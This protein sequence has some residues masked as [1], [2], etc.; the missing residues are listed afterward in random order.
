ML[1]RLSS[2]RSKRQPFCPLRFSLLM[3]VLAVSAWGRSP[4]AEGRIEVLVV[5]PTGK[6]VSNCPVTLS[7]G[8]GAAEGVERRSR[9]NESGRVLFSGLVAG[10]YR[11]AVQH[12][13]FEPWTANVD[14]AA[15]GEQTV[16]A[17]L[18]LRARREEVTVVATRTP[19]EGGRVPAAVG[20]VSREQV[21]LLQAHSL[22]D[23]FQYEPGM[24][25]TSTLRRSGETPNIRGMD[26]RRILVLQDGARIAEFPTG[27]KGYLFL[28]PEL[29]ERVE[30]LRGPASALYGS[31]ALG[32]VISLSTRDP[33]E[34]LGEGR[35]WDG[36]IGY[37]YST[38][39]HENS[40][41]LSLFGTEPEQKVQWF[42]GYAGRLSGGTVDL[43]GEPK[44][45][46]AAEEDTQAFNGKIRLNLGAETTFRV[47]FD[48]YRSEG[49]Q[50][51]NLESLSSDPVDRVTDRDTLGV[52][53]FH[54]RRSW[55]ADDIEAHFYVSD[56]DLD[57]DRVD[58]SGSRRVEF[59]TIGGDVRNSVQLGDNHRV[60][61]GL[62]LFGNSE[63]SRTE[64][65]NFDDLFPPGRQVQGGIY[66]QDEFELFNERVLL[67]PGVRFDWW[68]SEGGPG[69]DTSRS[70]SAVNW[71]MGGS[72]D[73]GAGLF[74]TANWA[75]GF[76]A[77]QLKELFIRGTHFQYTQ[78]S[79]VLVHGIFVPNPEL[80][81]ERGNAGDLGLKWMKGPVR[82]TLNL[83]RTAVRDFI[84]Y[85]VTS[86]FVPG[87]APKLLLLFQP[88]NVERATLR[89]VESSLSWTP[90]SRWS[91]EL[92]HSTMEG[93]N[94][95]G[96]SLEN[97][98][99]DK[100]ALRLVHRVPALGLTL[101]G[102]VR[103][104]GRYLDET[105]G[106]VLYDLHFEWR[107][108]GWSRASFYWAVENLTNRTYVGPLFAMPGA[109]RDLRFGLRMR[110]R[111]S[112]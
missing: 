107:P 96:E 61:Y 68:S 25:M 46:T 49:L 81:P 69:D 103:A 1:E 82:V 2:G 38:A 110:L 36:T 63:T 62:E 99:P 97:V 53:F 9:T 24:E 91:L 93:E 65:A 33:V 4:E 109:A 20:S 56:L 101:Q 60:T 87:P 47:S 34:L 71:R 27:H 42:L 94:E 30:V 58:G 7:G 52:E 66:I 79:G 32:G 92:S 12:R 16:R 85:R 100:F 98:M 78:P 37:G 76:R 3:L 6:A 51:A 111:S 39:F 55:W 84:D 31:G 41:R 83:W 14:L 17:T 90:H 64:E 43:A 13:A 10:R 23:L 70:R 72:Y 75:Q 59:R 77:P 45:L 106:Y 15:G 104:Y 26:E 89:G 50:S 19:L 112:D 22:A 29:V 105:P 74:V 80:L 88:A 11:V 57:E 40:L 18:A 95:L 73:L 8:A 86:E 21:E 5:D 44:T 108:K 102:A 54:H 35:L 48:K 67:V 28:D